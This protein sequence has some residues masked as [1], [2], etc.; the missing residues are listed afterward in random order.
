MLTGVLKE[1]DD[2]NST[3]VEQNQSTGS[4]LFVSTSV[5]TCLSDLSLSKREFDNDK[6]LPASL[7]LNNPADSTSLFHVRHTRF[8]CQSVALGISLNHQ[9]A[10]A[11]SL[12]QLVKDWAPIHHSQRWSKSLASLLMNFIE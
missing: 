4:V 7:Q 12:S 9:L 10:D 6:I 1:S 3:C 11:H 8:S 2:D 5:N